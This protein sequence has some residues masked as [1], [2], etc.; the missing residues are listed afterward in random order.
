MTWAAVF[1]GAVLGVSLG[2][3]G[4]ALVGLIYVRSMDAFGGAEPRRT[5]CRLGAGECGRGSRPAEPDRDAV[6]RV[7]RETGWIDQE[8]AE[9]VRRCG[10]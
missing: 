10:R 1:I 5:R 9:R 8:T 3:V 4:L 6:L 7:F 2:C